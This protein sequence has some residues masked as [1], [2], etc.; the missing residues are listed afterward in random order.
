MISVIL[1]LNSAFP[2]CLASNKMLFILE[3]V[4]THRSCAWASGYSG[5]QTSLAEG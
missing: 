3:I 4:S 5:T 1:S 2:C